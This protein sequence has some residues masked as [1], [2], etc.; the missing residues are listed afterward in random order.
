MLEKIKKENNSIIFG[1]RYMKNA[2]SFDDDMTT[3][4]GN[5]ILHLLERFFFV[6]NLRSSLYLYSCRNRDFKKM[7]LN[8]NNYN[9]CVEIP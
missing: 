9:L 7:K 1:S 8:S 6:K 4:I 5:F 2:G 3:K